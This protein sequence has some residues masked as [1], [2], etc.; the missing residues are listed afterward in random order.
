M[1][2]PITY[3]IDGKQYIALMGGLG[4]VVARNAEPGAAP[5]PATDSTILPKLMTFVL[6]GKPLP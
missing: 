5:P 2:P 1:G 6:D 3:Q 4:V